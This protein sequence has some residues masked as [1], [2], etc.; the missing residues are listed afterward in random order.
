[1]KEVP[2]TNK[3]ELSPHYLTA[4]PFPTSLRKTSCISV[5]G[6]AVQ[7]IQTGNLHIGGLATQLA[8]QPQSPSVQLFSRKRKREGKKQK[9][10]A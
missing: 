9:W 8:L 10:G 5:R 6:I 2:S 7:P 1:V 3:T 4:T